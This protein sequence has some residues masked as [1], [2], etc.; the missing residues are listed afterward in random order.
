MIVYLLQRARRLVNHRQHTQMSDSDDDDLAELD[1]LG[2]D[3]AY[4]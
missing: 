1:G 2:G 3:G 4:Y